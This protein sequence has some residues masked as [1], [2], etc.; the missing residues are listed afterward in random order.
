M[1]RLSPIVVF[2][3]DGT[4]ADTAQDL[5]AT[6]NVVMAR[7]NLPAI[8]FARARDLIGAGAKALI[9]RGFSVAEADLP[10][11]KLDELYDF[12]LDYYHHHIAVHTV[13]FPG[14]AEALERLAG[15][16][17]R[18]AVC[19][20]KIEAHAV[21]L[22]NVLGVLDR[23]AFVSGKD[24]FSVFKPDPGHLLQTIDRAG[25]AL[26]QAVMVGDSKTDIDTAKAA[27]VPVVGVS[28]GYTN[29]HVRDLGADVVIDH[30]DELDAALRPLLQ[31][32][33]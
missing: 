24:T 26:A 3:L 10:E 12:F 6:L 13:L 22:L 8:P 23:F 18:M 2:D 32:A 9:Q 5:V 15:A 30:F 1:H 33:A 14:V 29:V 25:G 17:V 16:G 4:L 27:R 31:A 20:N 11:A 21:E 19:T 28:F 7:E